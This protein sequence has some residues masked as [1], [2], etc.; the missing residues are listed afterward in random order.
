MTRHL[1]L[2]FVW[3]ILACGTA[4]AAEPRGAHA[5][6]VRD[7]I[8][9]VQQLASGAATT[10]ER[11]SGFRMLLH[12]G[13]DLNEVGRLM[14]GRYWRRTTPEQRVEFAALVEDYVTR[15]Y[16]NRF[17]EIADVSVAIDGT[18]RLDGA[19]MVYTTAVRPDG[20]PIHLDWRVSEVGGRLAVTD[21][22]VEGVSMVIAGRAEFS[23]IIR[24]SGGDI[25]GLLDLLRKRTGR[26]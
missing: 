8:A 15:L 9:D 16:E 24:Q 1:R 2:A 25:R 3:V 14:L 13:F 20:M 17:R 23:S 10:A 7:L 19:T 26:S 5:E 6:F 22:V 11:S 12:R 18:K 21:I 4:G